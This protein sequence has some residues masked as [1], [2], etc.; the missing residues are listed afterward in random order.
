MNCNWEALEQ[1]K[2]ATNLLLFSAITGLEVDLDIT[3]N[4][5]FD[6]DPDTD[7]V[8]SQFNLDGTTFESG[9]TPWVY[10]HRVAG[11]ELSRYTQA[12]M[13]S[14]AL[15]QTVIK[16]LAP[17][18]DGLTTT[19]KDKVEE[20]RAI[21]AGENLPGK[22]PG[23]NRV[24]YRGVGISELLDSLNDLLNKAMIGK[25]V[26]GDQPFLDQIAKRL[27]ASDLKNLYDAL[28]ALHAQLQGSSLEDTNDILQNLL[29]LIE[30]A[31]QI[32]QETQGT[33]SDMA[34]DMSQWRS[35]LAQLV[36]VL[37]SLVGGVGA[38]TTAIATGF[39]RLNLNPLQGIVNQFER[40][41]ESIA[42]PEEDQTWSDYFWNILGYGGDVTDKPS[43]MKLIACHI[44]TLQEINTVQGG[45]EPECSPDTGNEGETP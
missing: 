17:L 18:S 44:K 5:V 23:T 12:D 40:L 35:I 11:I 9:V 19:L 27:S 22:I 43:I 34:D 45:E 8:I 14:D 4:P 41:N 26:T 31:N 29:G 39:G 38:L 16:D 20:I 37:G 1:Q 24:D 30:Q 10:K 2:I 36:G 21:L 13:L 25:T 3:N 15:Y 28:Q 42:G 33:L 7:D 32:Q 6:R